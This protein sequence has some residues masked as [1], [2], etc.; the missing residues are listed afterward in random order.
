MTVLFVESD[1]IAGH[2]SSF[3]VELP[4]ELRPIERLPSTS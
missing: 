2:G 3:H 4:V 1:G